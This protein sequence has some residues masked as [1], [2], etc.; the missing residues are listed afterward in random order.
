M[1]L[2]DNSRNRKEI[3]DIINSCSELVNE[4]GSDSPKILAAE[5]NL[6][7]H[8]GI[9]GVDIEL[10]GM[11]PGD[12]VLLASRSSA[13]RSIVAINIVSNVLK[14]EKLP[15]VIFSTNQNKKKI[16]ASLIAIDSHVSLQNI[17]TGKVSF[18]DYDEVKIAGYKLCDA[19]LI[20][21]ADGDKS[22]RGIM[23][24]AREYGKSGFRPGMIVV[25][26]ISMAELIKTDGHDMAVKK[27]KDLARELNCIILILFGLS[28]TGKSYVTK[29][30]IR[31]LKN[32]SVL[33]GYIDSVLIAYCKGFRGDD[34]CDLQKGIMN[35]MI[36]K[37]REGSCGR[38]V[39]QRINE[40]TL[41]MDDNNTEDID[42]PF[43]G[44]SSEF[45]W[46]DDE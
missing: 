22:L 26:D 19:P 31:E 23:E 9:M 37:T 1:F 29:P 39:T 45:P 25:D 35:I 13:E 8:T 6:V 46:S 18:M 15:T 33:F 38:T 28:S 41:K 32:I 12:L 43:T 16:L 2:E 40:D 10:T 27:L 4:Y 42:L 21:S 7:V 20:I 36:P 14:W 5:S 17:L 34:F 30:G 11:C 3:K 24:R 44:G